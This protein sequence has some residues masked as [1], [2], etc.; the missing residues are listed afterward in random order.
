MTRS[1]IL[2]SGRDEGRQGHPA[3]RRHRRQGGHARDRV[4]D[5]A[6][7]ED[8]GLLAHRRRRARRRSSSW[9]RPSTTRP[10]RLLEWPPRRLRD[11]VFAHGTNAMA[12][13]LADKADAGATV[14][15]GGGDS[16]AAIAAA[17]PRVADD[18][19]LH[20]R[21]RLARVPRGPR[22][23]RR[24]RPPATAPPEARRPRHERR[25]DDR[26]RRRSRDPRFA[27]QSNGRGRRRPRRRLGRSGGRAV[28]RL[29]R[30]PRGR[31]APRRRREPV[32]AARASATRSTN[33]DRDDRPGDPRPRRGR[34]GRHRRAP[35]RARRDAEQGPTS[36]AN[37]ILG[38]S[39]AAAHAAPPRYDLPLYRYL[40]GVGARTLPVPMFN[41]LNGGK[42]AQDSTDF[43]EFMVMPVGVADVR[44][45]APRRL[46]DLRT[47]SRAILH[48]EGHATGQGD[49][50][51]FAP[52]LALQ[53]GRDRGRPAGDRAGRLPAR[54]GR[55]DRAR[56]GH[57]RARGA[58]PGSDGD[59]C[60]TAWRRRAGR[61]T[62]AN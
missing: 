29:D 1:G 50:G 54:R 24:R 32:T 31:R 35:D 33:V 40:G 43:Q 15:V 25:H 58:G 22:A 51:G 28:G 39:L 62:R 8:P 23:A 34:P 14:V 10:D 49:E 16:V 38:V 57:D 19:H 60:A 17:G 42:H 53:P 59:R 52:S 18:P 36:G 26:V 2:A 4:Q 45:R 37:A 5:A 11:P 12:R 46:G 9:R 13:F 6:G 44:R 56:P 55:R 3:G 48:D 30:R 20:R 41:I 7:R 27:R 61:S 47:P 21:R